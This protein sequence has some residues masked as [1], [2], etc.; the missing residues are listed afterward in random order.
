[1][2]AHCL[3]LGIDADGFLG[4]TWECEG[5]M[6]DIDE[7]M[8]LSSRAGI[9]YVRSIAA[10]PDVLLFVEVKVDISPWTFPGQF[11]T[12]DVLLAN[13]KKRWVIVFDWKYGMEPIYP[14]EN[15][16][17]LGYVLGA[18]NTLLGQLF[19]D[20]SGVTVEVV[21]EQPRVPGAGGSWKTTMDWVLEFGEFVKQRALLTTDPNA[22]RTAGEKQC[23]WCR[24]R[25]GCET[26][27]QWF[28][29]MMQV[30]FDD[31]DHVPT[32]ITLPTN[33]TPER[34]S[35][36]LDLAPLIRAWLDDLHKSAYHDAEHGRPTPGWKMVDGKRPRRQWFANKV[37]KAE[38]I[39]IDLFSED[40][41][42]EEPKL[43][44]PA[45]VQ[46]KL[47]KERYDQLFED[48]VDVGLPHPVL[49]SEKD[50]R[51]KKK[52]IEEIFD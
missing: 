27:A 11:G 50:R 34:R 2:V 30:S 40:G 6:I 10:D 20:S 25:Q 3:D 24:A 28:L 39:L 38:R 49:V 26:R 35:S 17:G 43:L 44:S 23:R 42:R 41:A 33:I 31:L 1:M 4:R 45:K 48:L 16:Q 37:H 9:E 46:K 36:L 14:Q 7:E 18:W 8:I 13:P 51:P 32:E 52:S 21:I 19:G 22:A 15:E 47:G 29:D 12:A 5:H